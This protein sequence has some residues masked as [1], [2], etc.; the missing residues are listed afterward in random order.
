LLRLLLIR[1]CEVSIRATK[2]WML[3]SARTARF[4]VRGLRLAHGDGARFFLSIKLIPKNESRQK[5]N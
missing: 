1:R 5:L 2:R 3:L 4:T